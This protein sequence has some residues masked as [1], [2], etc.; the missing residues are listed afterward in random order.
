MVGRT[1]AALFVDGRYIVQAP[2]QVD[3]RIFEVLQVPQAKLG[4]WLG[5]ASEEPAAWSASIPGC[6]RPSSIEELA[7]ALA[8]KGIKLKALAQ[9]PV[10][11]VWGRARPAPPQGAVIPHPLKYAGKPAEREDRRAAGDAAQ[12]RARTPSS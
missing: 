11:R 2:T 9:Q 12:G 6:I 3:T 1:A 7:K 4:D 10:D 5:K 8:A